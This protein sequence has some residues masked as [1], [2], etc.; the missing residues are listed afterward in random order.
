[1]Q[2]SVREL[3]WVELRESYGPQRFPGRW[4]RGL[5]GPPGKA[6]KGLVVEPRRATGP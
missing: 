2:A 6:R 4:V 3:C 1:M 5:V